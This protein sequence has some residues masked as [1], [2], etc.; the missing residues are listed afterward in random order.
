MDPILLG[1]GL[2]DHLPLAPLPKSGNPHAPRAGPLAAAGTYTCTC[3]APK[4]TVT[5]TALR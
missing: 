3:P 4:R 1:K 2:T 5:R